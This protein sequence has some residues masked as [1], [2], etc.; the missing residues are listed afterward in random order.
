MAIFNK[1]NKE[2][3]DRAIELEVDIFN[4]F[5]KTFKRTAPGVRYYVNCTDEDDALSHKYEAECVLKVLRT[6]KKMDILA[7]KI[8]VKIHK[9][10]LKEVQKV[11]RE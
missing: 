11:Y 4:T 7:Y 1:R 2:L 10:D 6:I 8:L 3:H 5:L 9:E